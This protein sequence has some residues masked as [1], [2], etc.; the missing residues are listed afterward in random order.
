MEERRPT[1]V[2]WTWPRAAAP[3]RR[4]DLGTGTAQVGCSRIRGARVRRAS[5]PRL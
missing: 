3:V 5:G 1:F 4:R 2:R